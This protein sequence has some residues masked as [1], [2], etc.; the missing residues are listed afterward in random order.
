[1]LS[2][3]DDRGMT[4][5]EVLLAVT[6]M[7]IIIGALANAMILF[8]R[9]TDATTSRLTE[10]HDVQIAAAYF[11]QDVEAT[12][13]H[14]WGLTDIP[15]KQS[16]WQNLAAGSACGPDAAFLQLS[17]DSPPNATGNPD[18]IAVAYVVKT[19][20]TE[21]Q[22]LRY[23]CVNGSLNPGTPQVLAH[24]LDAGTPAVTCL[25]SCAGATPPQKITM[26]IPI[27]AP[28]GSG[29]SITLTGQRRQT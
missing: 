8:S 2:K 19:V 24:N 15:L 28:R 18:V 17:W 11:A 10:S 26:V 5:I 4:L 9:N 27:K 1:M 16:V 25:T 13:L 12:G 20:G 21:R 23:R 22:L 6:L 7:A 14:N 3:G 29:V